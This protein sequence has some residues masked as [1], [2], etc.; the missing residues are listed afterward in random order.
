MIEIGIAS[1][2]DDRAA[3][4]GEEEQHDERR[5]DGADD[6]VLLHGVDAGAD[7][8]RVV[9]D[10]L[11][12]RARRA[13]LLCTLAEARL[14]GVDDGDGVLARLLDDR[15]QHG[16]L[17]VE[18][19]VGLLLGACR[20]RR[21]PRRRRGRR[22]RP[23]RGRRSGRAPSADATRPTTRR[24]RFSGPVSTLPPGVVRFCAAMA[25]CTSAAV[26]PCALERHRVEPDVDLPAR[27]RRRGSP[28]RRRRCSRSARRTCL[29]AISLTSR[30]GLSLLHGD[31]QD[32]RRAEVDL[33]DDRADR[34]PWAGRGGSSGSCRARPA[35]RR[36]RPS[37]GRT[38]SMTIETPSARRRA[39]LV[40]AGDGVDRALDLVADVGLDLLGRGAV[41]A[42]RHDD[43]RQSRRSGTGRG[44][45]CV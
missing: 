26:S 31:E 39:Q 3:D 8:A 40:D 25:R 37:R 11:E 34:C 44:R 1:A 17:A 19:G 10:D 29:S 38:G 35:R 13:A 5:E 36:R 20:P 27:A 4:V 28:G 16:A 15:E 45:A 22:G 12:L 9:A 14:D 23:A 2:G 7:D 30:M 43:E 32:R 41:E 18:R 24:V 21:G 42:R 6:E 33:A